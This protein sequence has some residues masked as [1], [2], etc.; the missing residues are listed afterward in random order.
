MFAEGGRGP[1]TAS[2]QTKN[3][4]FG[5]SDSGRCLIFRGGNHRSVASLPETWPRRFKA[6]GFLARR[7]T[8]HEVSAYGRFPT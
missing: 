8:V 6:C 4:E 2:S 3:L 5:G 1:R 7:P